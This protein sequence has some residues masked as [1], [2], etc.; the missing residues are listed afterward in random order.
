MDHFATPTQLATLKGT[1]PP[2]Q[3]E[4]W[5]PWRAAINSA[6]MEVESTA[7]DMLELHE[8]RIKESEKVFNVKERK[9]QPQFSL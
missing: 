8:S 4:K 5:K 7:M 6:A 2:R 9:Q 1:E 3:S